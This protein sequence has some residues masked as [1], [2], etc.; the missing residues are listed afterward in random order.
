[1]MQSIYYKL[2]PSLLVF[3]C[4]IGCWEL[5]GYYSDR[6]QMVLPAPSMI[7]GTLWSHADRFGFHTWATFKEM[8]GGFIIAI[9]MAF[10]L[11]WLMAYYGPLRAILQ[12]AFVMI[13]CVPMFALAP[14]MVIWF[15][16]SYMAI[17]V[18][19]AL[20]IFFPLTMNIYQGLCATPHHFLDFFR[21]HQATPWQTF[22]KLQLPWALPHIFAGF[23]ISAALAGIGAVAGEWAGAQHGLGLLMLESRRAADLPMTFAA[24][25]CLVMLSL[26]VYGSAIILEKRVGRRQISSRPALVTMLIFLSALL[27]GCHESTKPADQVK[28]V[29][30]WLPNPNHVPIYAG[31]E[32]GFFRDQGIDLM[33]YKVSDPSDVLPYLTSRQV[34]LCVTYMPHTIHAMING[35]RVEPIGILIQEPLNGMIYRKNDGVTLPVDLDGKVVGYCVDGSHTRVLNTMFRHVGIAPKE[36]H[37]VSFDL[38]YTLA[39]KHV[40]VIYGAYWNIEGENLRSLGVETDYFPLS[41]FGV[42]NYYELIVLANQGSPQTSTEFVAAFQKG[43]QASI[44]YAIAH[45]DEAFESYLRANPDK[46]MKTRIWEREAWRKTIPT[47]ATHQKIDPEIWNSFAGWL[48]E[49]KI[50]GSKVMERVEGTKETEGA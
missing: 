34:E 7:A 27:S 30:D 3:A 44:D 4:L 25:V 35:V 43:L 40:D 10:P 29:L 33:V 41:A 47:L 49:N 22:F 38:V 1:M 39:G 8:A 12:P 42:P 32:K 2:I 21:I 36:M 18:P 11:S 26:A 14:I 46:S 20:M 45:P 31:V 5:A 50:V 23:R 6:L 37:N 13:H 28:L 19:T 24:L 48:I 17:V 9:F 16:W 15:G